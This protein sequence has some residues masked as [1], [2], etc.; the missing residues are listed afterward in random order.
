[1]PHV[2]AAIV[3]GKN[4]PNVHRNLCWTHISSQVQ[5]GSGLDELLD[6]VPVNKILAFGGDYGRPVEK[7]VGH[8]HMAREDFARVFGARIARDMMS[9]DEATAIL[10][11]W[12]W[13]NPL[14][15]YQRVK[16]GEA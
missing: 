7:V 5:V 4:L 11:A 1:M 10:T 3:I 6:Q 15:L 13:D 2:R 8:L 12:V 14:A 9:F 16:V